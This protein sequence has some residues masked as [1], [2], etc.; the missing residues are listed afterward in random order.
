MDPQVK[1]TPKRRK[2]LPTPLIFNLFLKNGVGFF[3]CWIEKAPFK[4]SINK[5]VEKI[6]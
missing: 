2:K 6:N 4:I 3:Q 5:I 1:G